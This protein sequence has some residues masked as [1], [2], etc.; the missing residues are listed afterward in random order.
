MVAA[1]DV[2]AGVSTGAVVAVA[3]V[4][5]PLSLIWVEWFFR[6]PRVVCPAVASVASLN[7]V[8]WAVRFHP[9]PVP[10]ASMAVNVAPAPSSSSVH[11]K[12]VD[13]DSVLGASTVSV[14]PVRWR[15][16]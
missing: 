3:F 6:M 16:P 7:L 2:A 14:P 15:C 12:V 8:G 1:V 13:H 10:V 4:A 9:A 11:F 5:E